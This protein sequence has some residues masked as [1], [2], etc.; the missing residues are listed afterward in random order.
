MASF[1]ILLLAAAAPGLISLAALVVS[2]AAYRKSGI[3]WQQ[4]QAWEVEATGRLMSAGNE[5][6]ENR[7]KVFDERLDEAAKNILKITGLLNRTIGHAEKRGLNE[8]GEPIQ[9]LPLPIEILEN[10][11]LQPPTPPSGLKRQID[12]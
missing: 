7:I 3:E 1:E 4:L 10:G 2:I 12:R 11:Q 6:Y 9:R 5:V 8:A